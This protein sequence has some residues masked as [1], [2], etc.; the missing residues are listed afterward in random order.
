MKWIIQQ[1]KESLYL[2]FLTIMLLTICDINYCDWK[3]YVILVP[4]AFLVNLKCYYWT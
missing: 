2:I 1:L 3:L 4:T